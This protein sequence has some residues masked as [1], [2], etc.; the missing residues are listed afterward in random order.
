MNKYELIKFFKSLGITVHT[1]TKA[2]GHHGFYLKNRIDISKNIPEHRVVPTLLHEFAHY[3]HSKIGI[4]TDLKVLFKSDNPVIEEE[5]LRVTNF[6]DENSLCVRLHEHKS[7]V[8]EKIKGFEKVIKQDY[9]AFKRSKKFKEFDKYIKGSDA[10][11][12][13]KYDRVKVLNGFFRRKAQI[14]TID[15]IE[16]NFPEMPRAFAAYLRLKSGQRKQSRICARINRYQ[17]YYKKPT[18]L[19]ARLVEGLYSD[20]EQV[21]A[22]APYSTQRFYELLDE[23]YYTDL[24]TALDKL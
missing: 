11:Y 1:T 15:S 19:F 12:L 2:R 5:L 13:L 8:K 21:C 6:V 7:R 20:K 14:Y 24:K 18:E 23:G 10:K 17:K 4:D 16:H 3:I 22:L 9:P